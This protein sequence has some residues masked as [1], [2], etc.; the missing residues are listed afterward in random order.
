MNRKGGKDG[1]SRDNGTN[2]IGSKGLAKI[3][4]EQSA[5]RKKLEELRNKLNKEGKGAGNALNPL[6][7]ELKE[8]QKNIIN[9]NITKETIN[10]QQE[11]LTRLLESEKAL[12]ERGFEDKRESKS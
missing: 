7:Q 3:A 4:A 6:I 8:Q 1:K 9:K 12:I 11:I 5:I 2:G 10:R